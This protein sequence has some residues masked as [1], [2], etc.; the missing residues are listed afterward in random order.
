LADPLR[1]VAY[2]RIVQLNVLDFLGSLNQTTS[3]EGRATFD[4]DYVEFEDHI[5][6]SMG[7]HGWAL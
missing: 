6:E 3:D 2:D 4:W 5:E 7:V 1:V